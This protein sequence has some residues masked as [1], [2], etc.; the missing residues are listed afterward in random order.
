M[1]IIAQETDSVTLKTP[2]NMKN[3]QNV[4][5]HLAAILEFGLKVAYGCQCG[6]SA[7]I[8]LK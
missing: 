7:K 3:I 4:W 8:V 5:R 6:N 1:G 2:D